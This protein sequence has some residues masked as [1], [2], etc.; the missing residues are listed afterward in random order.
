VKLKHVTT[1]LFLFVFLI[2]AHTQDIKDWIKSVEKLPGDKLYI[3]TD[4]EFYFY[5]DTLWFAAY[6]L[7]GSNLE[8]SSEKCNLYVELINSNGKITQ[9]DFFPIID[10]TCPG[11]LP[12]TSSDFKEGNYLLRAYTDYLKNFGEDYFFEKTIKLSET[13]SSAGIVDS[14]DSTLDLSG[15]DIQF[16]PEGDFF[17][18]IISTRLHLKPSIRKQDRWIL[19]ERFWMKTETGF[20]RLIQFTREWGGFILPRMQI[21]NTKLKLM[22]ILN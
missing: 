17:W 7:N 8:L 14:S 19:R 12:F 18:P 20:A 1:L 15:I 4:R 2:N 16:F 5:G 3:H 9:K 11:Y 22:N 6:L 21:Q 13:Q 10:G